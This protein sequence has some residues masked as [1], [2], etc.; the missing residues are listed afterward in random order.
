MAFYSSERKK[1]AGCDGTGST[2][3][4]SPWVAGLLSL[5]APGAGQVYNGDLGAGLGLLLFPYVLH[6]LFSITGLFYSFYGFVL[7]VSIG[8]TVY[9]GQIV[10]A[11]W[12]A[13]PRT[14][15][16]LKR[17]NK[18]LV[19]TG[20]VIAFWGVWG[21]SKEVD[22]LY[23]VLGF[24]ALRMA[25]DGSTK[26]T[27]L[28]GD[29]FMVKRGIEPGRPK[30]GDLI[31]YRYGDQAGSMIFSYC[32][33]DILDTGDNEAK[34]PRVARVVGV[35]GDK[36]ELKNGSFFV[37]DQVS[38]FPWGQ[39][40]SVEEFENCGPQYVSRNLVLLSGENR[41]VPDCHFIDVQL[42]MGRIL[43][44]YFSSDL[45]RVGTEFD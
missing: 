18:G 20:L 24:Q 28:I 40:C 10:H 11:C 14:N 23:R 1:V 37:N 27:L 39:G 31:V 32:T 45:A 7:C 21:G 42:I 43:Y 19:Y 5:L 4:R 22:V 2:K 16:K 36:V 9:I 25:S 30:R 35:G 3:R 12:V 17:Y 33:R 8:I 34:S 26:P 6:A 29:H 44:I 41:T 13:G 38:S 15:H